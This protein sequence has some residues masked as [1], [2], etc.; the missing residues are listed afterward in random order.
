[1]LT[2]PN[3]GLSAWNHTLDP[4]DSVQLAAN[5]AKLDE[6]DHTLGKGKRITTAAIEDGAITAAKIAAGAL[7]AD[8]SGTLALRPAASVLGRHYYATDEGCLYYDTGSAWVEEAWASIPY[9]M[10]RRLANQ[11]LAAGEVG[12]LTFD[13]EVQDRGTIDQQINLGSSATRVYVRKDGVYSVEGA[14][15]WQAAGSGVRQIILT[16]N[17]T[18]GTFESDGGF[19]NATADPSFAL[20]QSLSRTLS[21]VSGDY[22][23]L[24]YR[25]G[26]SVS[27]SVRGHLSISRIGP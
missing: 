2:L 10:A 21:C 27:R 4:Y 3:L 5:F 26:D 25:N 16:K 24:G 8:W 12:N 19:A 9:A 6:H 14:L 7:T 18:A 22:F 15:D 13:T 20:A 23:S 11:T 1:M 17:S